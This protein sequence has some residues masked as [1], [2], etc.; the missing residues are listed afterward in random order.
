[1]KRAR[2]V[3]EEVE[4]GTNDDCISDWRHRAWAIPRAFRLLARHVIRLEALKAL[5]QRAL[6]IL[7]NIEVLNHLY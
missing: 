5:L 1:M 6:T 7:P 3:Q 2:F 4:Q